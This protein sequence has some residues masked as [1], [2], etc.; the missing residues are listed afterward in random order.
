MVNSFN[1]YFTLVGG[2][3]ALKANQNWTLDPNVYATSNVPVQSEQFEFQLVTEKDLANVILNLPS[4]K[5][6]CFDKIPARILKDSL[7]ATLHVVMS[8][9][10]SSFRSNTFASVWKIAEVICFPKDGDVE[11]PCNMLSKQKVG[12]QIICHILERQQQAI[13]PSKWQS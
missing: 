2:L 7:P 12:P 6:P 13:T 5:A 11:N 3:T 10:N 9:M 4:D 1:T 8:L